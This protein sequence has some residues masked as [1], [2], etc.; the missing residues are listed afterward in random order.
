M[1]PRRALAD[2]LA[3]ALLGGPALALLAFAA[4][5]YIHGVA[6]GLAL[7]ALVYGTGWVLAVRESEAGTE[8]GDDSQRE[9]ELEAEKSGYGGNSG[10]G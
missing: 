5:A 1:E 6:A 9:R 7:A 2:N 10:G 8:S 4:G 3:Y